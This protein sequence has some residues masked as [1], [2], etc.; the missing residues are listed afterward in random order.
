MDIQDFRDRIDG[1]DALLRAENMPCGPDVWQLVF[2]LLRRLEQQNRL[3][4]DAHQLA[5]LL[6]PLFCR[7]PEDQARFSVLF[8]QWLS[9]DA[10]TIASVNRIIAPL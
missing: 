4:D 9:D 7:N 1:L 6:G 10:A 8:K 2:M 3:P 5:P